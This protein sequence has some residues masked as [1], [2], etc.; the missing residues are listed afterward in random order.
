LGNKKAPGEDG[1]TGE[2]YKSAFENFPRY[3]TA[4]YNG[5]LNR[6][7]FPMRWKRTK[8]VA[9]TQP[10]KNNSEDVTKFRP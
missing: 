5:S 1:I 3:T 2:I 4:M 10:G 9:I 6:G 7:A 8:L